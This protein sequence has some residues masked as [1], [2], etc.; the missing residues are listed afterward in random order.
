MNSKIRKRISVLVIAFVLV[1]GTVIPGMMV[2]GGAESDENLEKMDEVILVYADGSGDLDYLS[3]HGEIIDHYGRNVILETSERGLETIESQYEVRTLNHRNELIVNGYEFDTNEGLPEL[4]EEYTIESYEQ[5]TEGIYLVDMIGPISSDWVETLE[6]KSVEVMNYVHNYGYRVL[7]TPE[8]AERVENLEFVDWVGIYQPEFKI[9]PGLESGA[10]EVGLTP[11]ADFETI[12]QITEKAA[13]ET[14]RRE[15]ELELAVGNEEIEKPVISHVELPD[16]EHRVRMEIDEEEDL[17]EI[18]MI[19]EVYYISEHEEPE[20]H[21]MESQLTGGGLWFMD[22]EDE[23]NPQEPYRK[24]GDYGAYI[25]QIGYSGEDVTITIADTGIGDSEEGDAGHPDFT[26]RVVGGY[27]WDDPD[28]W[29]DG[30]YHG[31][32][33]AGLAAGHTYGGTGETYAGET[34]GPYYLSQGLAYE[35]ELY[36]AKIFGDDGATWVG[37]E[38]YFEI[39]EVPAQ[40]SDTYIHSNSWGAD[41]FG[42]YIETDSV[43]DSAVRDANRETEENE[44]MVITS[45]AGNA[46]PGYQS[47]GSPGHAKNVITVGATYNWAPDGGDYGGVNSDNPEDIVGYSSRGWTADNRIKPDVVAPAELTTSTQTPQGTGTYEPNPEEY[48]WMGGT[49]SSNP[50][51]AGAASVI[52]EWYEENHGYR[53]SPAMVRSLLINTAEP[54]SEE[55]GNTEGP[56]PNRDEGWGM[57]DISKLEYPKEDQLPFYTVDQEEELTDSGEYHEYTVE[58]EDPEEP[59]KVTLGWA[60]EAAPPDAFDDPTLM[61]DLNLEVVS[62]EGEVYQ[63]NAFEEGW[64]QPNEDTMEVFDRKGDGWDDTNNVQNVYI[65]PEDLVAGN[66]SVR[67]TGANIVAD[68]VNIG[69]TSQDYALAVH[70]AEEAEMIHDPPTV[71]VEEPEEDTVWVGHTEEDIIWDSTPGD[72]DIDKAVLWYTTDG[73]QIWNNIATLEED[74][75]TYTW[76]V[77]NPTEPEVDEAQI[78]IRVIDEEGGYGEAVSD[79]FTIEGVPPEPPESL[80]VE[81]HYT[82]FDTIFEDNVS[83]DKGYMTMDEVNEWDIR[84]HGAAVGEQSWDWGNETYEQVGDDSWLVSPTIDLT[85]AESAEFSFQHW[86]DMEPEWDGGTLLI[87][88]DGEEFGLIDD[89]E[90]GYDGELNEGFDNPMEGLPA[91]WGSEDWE[92]VTVDLDEYAGE[93][94]NIAWIASTHDWDEW[95]GGWRID[96]IEMTVEIERDE[97]VNNQLRWYASPSE[98]VGEVSHYNVYRAEDMEGPWDEPIGSVEAD[99]SEKYEYIDLDAAEEPYYWYV[100][101]S[102]G[103]NELEE[104][105]EEAKQ[106]PGDPDVETPEITI[107]QPDA[108]SVWDAYDLEDIMWTTEEAEENDEPVE[109]DYIDHLSYSTDGGETWTEIDNILEDD[110]EYEWEVANWPSD[111]AMIQARVVD[112]YGRFHEN[113]SEEFEIVGQPPQQPENLEVEHGSLEEEWHWMYDD[114]HRPEADNAIGLTGPGE[115][116]TAM[117]IELP[118]GQVEDIAYYQWDDAESITGTIHE[119]TG[120]S[121]GEMLGQTETMTEFDEQEWNEIP[122]MEPVSIDSGYYWVV[123]EVEDIGDG[124]QP[125]GTVE[126]YLEDA[127]YI[128]MDGETWDELIGLGFDDSWALEVNVEQVDEDG[129]DHNVLSWDASPDDPADAPEQVTHYNIYRADE[130]TGPWDEEALI[131]TVPADGSEDYWYLDP[132]MGPAQNDTRLWYVVRAVALNEMEEQNEDAAQEPLPPM[133]EPPQRVRV[134]EH[135][136]DHNKITWVESPDEYRIDEYNVY[137][138]EDEGGPW[139]DP[140]ATVEADEDVTEYEYID[141]DAAGEPFYWYLVRAVDNYGQE[142]D[143]EN[144]KYEPGDPD[145]ESPEIEITTP[146]GGEEWFHYSEQDL[147]WNT[148]EGDEDIDYVNL[149]YSVD[150]GDS[151]NTIAEGL[152]DTGEYTWKVPDHPT[153]EAMIRAEVVD[154]ISYYDEDTSETFEIIEDEEPP[155]IEITYPEEDAV[156]DTSNVT[157]EWFG[158][159]EYSGLSHFEV[160]C[161]EEQEWMDVGDDTSFEF[162]EL[163]EGEHTV[164]VKA[165]DN[166]GNEAIDSVTFIVDTVPPEILIANPEDGEYFDE[167]EV[168]VQWIGY[169]ETTSIEYYEVWSPIEDDWIQVGH[170][171]WYELTDLPDGEHSVQVR[172]TDEAGNQGTEEAMF[173]VDT[174]APELDIVSPAEG[175]EIAEDSVE[176]AWNVLGEAEKIEV[177]LEDTGWID[178]DAPEPPAQAGEM[179]W[180][181]SEHD[182]KVEAVY[183]SDGVIYSGADIGLGEPGEVIA[184][185]TATGEVLWSHYEHTNAVYGIVEHDGVVYSGCFDGSVIAADADTGEELWTHDHHD[186]GVY[187]LTVVDD[188]IVSGGLGGNVIAADLDD[189]EEIWRHDHHGEAVFDVDA[190]DGVVYSGSVGQGNTVIAADAEDGDM[191][192]EH[193][194]HVGPIYAV[195]ASE[196]LVYSA[197]NDGEVV[198]ASVEDGEEDWSHTH[199]EDAIIYALSECEGMVFS[200]GDD[201]RVLAADAEDGEMLWSHEH[202]EHFVRD[203]HASEGVVYSGAEDDRVVAAHTEDEEVEPQTHTFNGVPDGENTAYV[204]ATDYAGNEHVEMVD[205]TIDTTPPDIEFTS[206]ED[207]I[208]ELTYEEELMIEGTTHPE[209]ELWIDGEMVDVDEEGDFSYTLMLVEGQNVI[210][211]IAEDGAGN[212]RQTTVSALYLPEIPEIWN[213]IETIETDIDAIEEDIGDLRDDLDYLEEDLQGQI[214]DLDGWIDELSDDLEE[215]EEDLQSQIDELE[216]DID[217]IEADIAE[218][219][220][221]IADIEDDITALEDDIDELRNDLEEFKE[222]QEDV[223]EDQ[224]DDIDMARNLGIVGIV[225]AILAVIIAVFAVMQKKGGSEPVE[226]EMVGESEETDFFEE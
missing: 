56:I 187:S 39:L 61:N 138:S 140:I 36:S 16:G 67:V 41:T 125:T 197:G 31:T 192:W 5:G 149:E 48:R 44:P 70:N 184:Y 13:V 23:W 111:E 160:W 82:E 113:T 103:I 165:V 3:E 97:P 148:I 161:L 64:T 49:S 120:D 169:E 29:G 143:N 212:H 218:I 199:H 193:E 170:R 211:V 226:E 77:I 89:P 214:D 128:S 151:W 159:D 83:E 80:L 65:P 223:E 213:S 209:A 30:H 101:R 225:L 190:H 74:E 75:G 25:N 4:N 163:G 183:E 141:E 85:E 191:I 185:D 110:G 10:I 94:V 144:S 90:P 26:D 224:E 76:D 62:P 171:T 221:D 98:D 200:G 135:E 154:V 157:V 119:D 58:H 34:T 122:L 46:G 166:A 153:D 205:L 38:D 6:E 47:T 130:E 181:H 40:E 106:E 55:I 115:Y 68:A 134:H 84:D 202:H 117:R 9:Q 198:A 71:E 121:P 109:I 69:E 78:R 104:E 158:E 37:P 168:T 60:D 194:H 137:R 189:G 20:L 51:A 123:L 155:T 2:L 57:V 52:V 195:H 96:D 203:I 179:I 150:G 206:P 24:H 15:N 220:D 12:N 124:F 178:Y 35:S 176:V 112:E 208:E 142:E 8:Q 180:E 139:D 177:R 79:E 136:E 11:N 167:G 72:Y 17:Y 32:H 186:M 81:D 210:E 152:E 114:D 116:W 182:G 45:S 145:V 188:M 108:D 207:G 53:P 118:R 105:N 162:E 201:E 21:E 173:T 147:D 63:G 54:L 131:D 1:V 59:M 88:T 215:V 196:E 95:D 87:S 93:T 86:R 133:V 216:V 156:L 219:E 174:I 146:E 217:D 22:D 27:N 222:D 19:D 164:E 100:V 28:Y 18:A 129:L 132:D 66:Y 204:R 175:E 127:G 99:G 14:D 73:G 172:A 102:V 107:D 91:W 43:F 126:G 42:E 7:M 92:E 33:A 50:V